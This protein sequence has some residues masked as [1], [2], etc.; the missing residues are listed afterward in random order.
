MGELHDAAF[1]AGVWSVIAARAKELADQAKADL[2]ALEVGDTVAG[3]YDGQI[4][5]KATKTKGRKKLRVIN[6]TGFVEW[7]Y[8]R[9][10]DETWQIRSIGEAFRKKLEDKALALGAL[11]DDDGEVCP[12]VEVVEGDPYITVRKEKDAPFVVAQLLS[13]GQLSLEPKRVWDEEIEAGAIG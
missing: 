2:Q 4:I 11:I 10:P 9:W 7:V 8:R 12:H 5:A 3:R 1:R 6:E 13:S